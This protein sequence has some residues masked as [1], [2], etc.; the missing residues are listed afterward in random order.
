MDG[1]TDADRAAFDGWTD[2]LFMAWQHA[3]SARARELRGDRSV[4]FTDDR[5]LHP[6]SIEW[7]AVYA[8][9]AGRPWLQDARL[10]GGPPADPVTMRRLAAAEAEA[11]FAA[12]LAAGEPVWHRQ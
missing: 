5:G 1:M 2:A 6:Y 11:D 4:K 12:S 3:R 10:H 8:L 9:E 7:G